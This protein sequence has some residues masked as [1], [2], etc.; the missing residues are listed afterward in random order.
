M[1]KKNK[2]KESDPFG[3]DELDPPEDEEDEDWD[4][5]SD[6]DDEEDDADE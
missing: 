2:T 3:D 5:H 4:A 6:D 1:P